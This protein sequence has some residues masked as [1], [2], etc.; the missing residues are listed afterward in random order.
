M[1]LLPYQLASRDVPWLMQCCLVSLFFISLYYP[2]YLT[3]FLL[4][5]SSLLS[6]THLISFTICSRTDR[7]LERP[8]DDFGA[9]AVIGPDNK[10][11]E[12]EL[13]GLDVYSNRYVQIQIQDKD[14]DKDKKAGALLEAE[15]VSPPPPRRKEDK[16]HGGKKQWTCFCLLVIRNQMGLDLLGLWILD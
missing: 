3:V 11:M 6:Q 13:S 7:L 9:A 15:K 12:D 8:S 1:D 4:H 14:K 5:T 16:L 2:C 10:G